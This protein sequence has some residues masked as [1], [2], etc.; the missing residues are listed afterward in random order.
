ML[1]ADPVFLLDVN[2]LLRCH[3]R[4]AGHALLGVADAGGSIELLRL[5][6]SEVSDGASVVGVG[7]TQMDR[8]WE[9]RLCSYK[10][11]SSLVSVQ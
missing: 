10:R 5:V 6:G 7:G 2:S 11:S 3:I 8:A 9:G 1:W 4:V